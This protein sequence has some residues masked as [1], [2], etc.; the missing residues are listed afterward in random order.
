MQEQ[1]NEQL[2]DGTAVFIRPIWPED[3]DRE[4]RYIEGLSEESR[5]F[6]FLGGMR[7]P[8]AELLRK[9][10]NIDPE[11]DAAYVA[12]VREGSEQR[13][14]GAARYSRDADAASC[15]CAV[16]V[17]DDFQHRGLGTLLMRHLIENAR[18]KGIRHMYSV[19]ATEN[20]T[21]WKFAE[22]LGFKRHGDPDDAC[23]TR[24]T[25]ELGGRQP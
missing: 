22:H 24:H 18:A 15:E 21:M 6:R 13:Q 16:S 25:L 5:Y 2:Q 20:R 12:L 3:A 4:R 19:D 8:S 7:T 14:V 17:S 23:L 9:L 1:W 10:T 11:R